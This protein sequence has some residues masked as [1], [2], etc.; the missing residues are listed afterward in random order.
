MFEGQTDE[1]R[2]QAHEAV[3]HPGVT[4]SLFSSYP[5]ST[6]G[7]FPVR[8]PAAWACFLVHNTENTVIS[9]FLSKIFQLNQTINAQFK[10]SVIAGVLVFF[11]NLNK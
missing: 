1:N 8:V 11:K 2:V 6:F 7:L 9:T 4:A 3:T 5:L 10:A